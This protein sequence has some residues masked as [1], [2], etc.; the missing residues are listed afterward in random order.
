MR[1]NWASSDELHLELDPAGGRRAAVEHAI[2]SAIRDGRLHPGDP[3]PSARALARDLGLARGTVAEAYGQLAAEGFLRS[4]PRGATRI[5]AMATAA[6]TGADEPVPE[7]PRFNLEIGEPD[8]SGFPRRAWAAALR[9]AL[10]A[11]PDTAML[12][13]D[14]RGRPELRE[15][16]AGHLRRTRGA[17]VD[18]ARVVV[19]CGF[20]HALA[21]VAAAARD[22]GGRTLALEDPC[23]AHHRRIAAGSLKVVPLPVDERGALVPDGDA[24]VAVLTPAHQFPFGAT[25]APERRTAFVGWARER[26]ALVL[27]DDYDGEFRYDRQ[28]VG[29]LQGLDP[30]C[31]AYAGT[32]SKT[33]APGLRLAWLVLPGAFVEP[34]LAAK[35]RLGGSPSTLDQIAL[36]E[37]LRSGAYDRHVRRMRQR[38]RRRRDALL[39]MLGRA[40]PELPTRGIAAGLHLLAEL[41]DA[42]TERRLVE[43]AAARGLRVNGMAGFWHDPAGR[44]S[45]L[46]LGYATPPEHGYAQALQ[47]LEDVLEYCG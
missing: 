8:V 47:A 3:L 16:L 34:A 24:A 25:L 30:E 31:V 42:A 45:G 17:L 33:L 28:P 22:T 26:G 1:E 23:V 21:I 44:Q 41:P 15:A 10:T 5:A 37:L 40:A 27:E 39:A 46:V 36:A 43:T 13:G 11:A 6:P 2:R 19:C 7:R 20:S 38:Y 29:A 32:A 12:V 4:T 9:Q 35:E 14:P 18:P